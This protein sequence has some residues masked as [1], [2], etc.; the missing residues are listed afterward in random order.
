MN[1]KTQHYHVEQNIVILST[2]APSPQLL[3][4]TFLAKLLTFLGKSSW[5][6]S[7]WENISTFLNGLGKPCPTRAHTRAMPCRRCVTKQPCLKELAGQRASERVVL[8]D[9]G[10]HHTSYSDLH[11]SR[12]I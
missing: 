2:T 10:W 8:D 7:F 9:D 5:E 3:L 12:I 6:K 1:I 11:F 4:S